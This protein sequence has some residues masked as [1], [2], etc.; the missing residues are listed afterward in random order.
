MALNRTTP[1]EGPP[2]E[3]LLV[4]IKFLG[5]TNH[6]GSRLAVSARSG[7]HTLRHTVPFDHAATQE[8][9]NLAAV[10]SFWDR[11]RFE[12][13]QFDV[14]YTTIRQIR[15]GWSAEYLYL[16]Q[17]DRHNSRT[18]PHSRTAAQTAAQPHSR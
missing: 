6:R 10:Q 12:L 5:P 2:V 9:R 1:Q 11:H 15:E 18:Q 16:L 8:E 4:R 7:E 17:T 13:E 14:A 3:G